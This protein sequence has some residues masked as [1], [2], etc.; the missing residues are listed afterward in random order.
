MFRKPLAAAAL[1][2]LTSHAAHATLPTVGR[3]LGNAIRAHFLNNETIGGAAGHAVMFRGRSPA[4]ACYSSLQVYMIADTDRQGYAAGTGGVIR[5]RVTTGE[6]LGLAEV[7][8]DV[9]GEVDVDHD[10][11]PAL[12]VRV[13]QRGELARAG[14]SRRGGASAGA[15]AP[16]AALAQ[17]SG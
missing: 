4:A 5:V 2:A 6:A 9:G 1:L 16:A 3:A 15:T 8:D 13:P 12:L 10:L 17:S 14:G 7:G 11:A